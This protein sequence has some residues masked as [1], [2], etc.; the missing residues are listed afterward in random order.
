MSKNRRQIYEDYIA[1]K[2]WQK[3]RK[4]VLKR[5]KCCRTCGS[6]ERLE[7]HHW[8]YPKYFK[9]DVIENLITLCF[10]CHEAITNV[11]RKKRYKNKPIKDI[12]TN[13]ND[14]IK[15]GVVNY[16]NSKET[17]IEIYGDSTVNF[18]QRPTR[19]PYKSNSQTD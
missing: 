3:L 17:K 12:E 18:T 16:G 9:D 11:I 6:E 10:D 1:S 13:I 4:E 8:K 5:D 19:Q 15:Q 2:E 7:A 14:T